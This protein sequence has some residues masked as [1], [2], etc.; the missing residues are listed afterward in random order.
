MSA[1]PA[2]GNVTFK[3][4]HLADFNIHRIYTDDITA[5]NYF[6]ALVPTAP[7]G[8]TGPFN[9]APVLGQV[10]YAA[11]GAIGSGAGGG[12]YVYTG[13]AGWVHSNLTSA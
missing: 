11:T 6:A 13:A 5:A 7:T 1:N 9:T 3:N 10:V 12:L 8:P 4:R 2:P